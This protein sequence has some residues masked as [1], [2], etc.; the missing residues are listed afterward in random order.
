LKL[1]AGLLQKP[2][3]TWPGGSK[4]LRALHAGSGRRQR[5]VTTTSNQYV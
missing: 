3:L 4:T 1:Q 2:E 5:P